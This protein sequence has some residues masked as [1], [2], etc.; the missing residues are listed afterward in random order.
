LNFDDN[1]L[2]FEYEIRA[3]SKEGDFKVTLTPSTGDPV[4]VQV[5]VK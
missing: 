5:Q 2:D 3:A 1:S 4:V